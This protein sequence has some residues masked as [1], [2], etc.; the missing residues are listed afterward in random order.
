[1]ESAEKRPCIMHLVEVSNLHLTIHGLIA[2]YGGRETLLDFIEAE[3]KTVYERPKPTF[4]YGITKYERHK[5]RLIKQTTE[6]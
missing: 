5:L 6:S 1:M 3:Q 2:K 4:T